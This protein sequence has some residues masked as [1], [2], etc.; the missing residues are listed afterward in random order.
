MK[1][2][3]INVPDDMVALFQVVIDLGYAPS[4]SEAVRRVL[5]FGLPYFLGLNEIYHQIGQRNHPVPKF[6]K[7]EDF[8]QPTLEELRKEYPYLNDYKYINEEELT[9]E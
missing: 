4:R 7:P 8:P 2:I 9:L 5:D 1:I 6:K 3:T